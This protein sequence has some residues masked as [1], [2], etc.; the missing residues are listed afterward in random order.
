MSK[1]STVFFISLILSIAFF[2]L[3]NPTETVIA[4]SSAVNLWASV[5]LP[6][7]LP[8]FI[9]AELLVSSGFVKFLG[10]ILEPIMRPLFRLPGASSI[11]VVM[12]FTSGFPVGAIL[13][14]KLYD[15]KILSAEETERLVSFTNNSSPLFIL[16]AVGVGMFANPLAGYI[17]AVS[18]Y[19]SN[20]FVGFL[21]RFRAAE[22]MVTG[23]SFNKRLDLAWQ[24]II[25]DN[26][27][28]QKNIIKILGDAIK[29]SIN[30]ILMVGG[31]IVVFSVLTRM[32]TIWGFMDQL[33]K[34]IMHLLAPFNL[35]YPLAYGLGT[36]IFEITLGARTAVSSSSA[37]LLPVLLV[38]SAILA[39]SGLSIIAQVMNIV[40][41]IP[42][43]MSF[44][45][46]SRFIQM[47]LSTIITLIVYKLFCSKTISTLNLNPPPIH[48]WLYGFDA[49]TFSVYCL[50]I[51]FL[52]III[53]IALSILK[54]N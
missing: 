37:E 15:E 34:I 33:A 28:H 47:I 49:W 32:L 6:A 7:L 46:L 41:S 48:K 43:R 4:T 51:S 26:K 27:E 13:S 12:G 9:V 52:V 20:L 25:K 14:K 16:G 38:V 19:L 44:Y 42:V 30:H 1:F 23:I 18:H 24:P 31:F 2:M 53:M 29:N 50:L 39:F 21:W 45:L 17:L 11:V 8:F 22:P 3:I 5:V 40:S 36:G 54:K 35:S 10:V